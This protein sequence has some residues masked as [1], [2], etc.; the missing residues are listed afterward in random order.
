MASVA[1]TTTAS[2]EL[3]EIMTTVVVGSGGG[4]PHAGTSSGEVEDEFEVGADVPA[5]RAG[6]GPDANPE[7]DGCPAA[8]AVVE[9]DRAESGA[10]ADGPCASD[11]DDD[12]KSGG[13]GV[14]MSG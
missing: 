9:I 13:V 7:K 1:A 6:V 12:R 10:T 2:V 4:V 11:D 14:E 5:G 3:T 8:S